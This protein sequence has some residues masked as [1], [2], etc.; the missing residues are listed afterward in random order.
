MLNGLK[1]YII[2]LLA[3]VWALAGIS[4]NWIEWNQAIPVIE[5]ALGLAGIRHA[6]ARK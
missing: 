4:F 5:V 3:L 2:A 6:I 1:T